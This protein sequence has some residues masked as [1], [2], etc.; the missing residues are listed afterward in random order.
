M[1]PEI[2]Q[3]LLS[4]AFPDFTWTVKDASK[5]HYFRVVC[6]QDGKPERFALV[7]HHLFK[8]NALRQRNEIVVQIGSR[9]KTS[10]LTN[11]APR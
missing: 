6:L 8:A 10:I 1:S 9:L 11:E 5:G 7:P 4:V 3:M 2:L